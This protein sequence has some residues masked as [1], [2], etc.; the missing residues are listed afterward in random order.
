MVNPRASGVE[1]ALL[2][3]N[4]AILSA[5]QNTQKNLAVLREEVFLR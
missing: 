5:H 3:W 1:H 2:T 4:K